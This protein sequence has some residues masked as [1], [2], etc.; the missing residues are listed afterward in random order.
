MTRRLAAAGAACAVLGLARLPSLVLCKQVLEG[1]APTPWQVTFDKKPGASYV[2]LN[3]DGGERE[4]TMSC[5]RWFKTYTF[6]TTCSTRRMW[7]KYGDYE[8]M[9]YTSPEGNKM[10]Y[11]KAEAVCAEVQAEIVSIHSQS[12]AE[13]VLSLTENNRHGIWISAVRSTDPKDTMRLDGKKRGGFTS[14]SDDTPWDYIN[15]APDEPSATCDPVKASNCNVLFDVNDVAYYS[16]AEKCVS[17]GSTDENFDPRLW[18][19]VS[20]EKHRRLVCKRR[21]VKKTW[22]CAQ[23]NSHF[24]NVANEIMRNG[25]TIWADPWICSAYYSNSDNPFGE[26]FCEET[27]PTGGRTMGNTTYA[28]VCPIRC[29]GCTITTTTATLP[30]DTT[31]TSPAPYTGPTTTTTAGPTSTEGPTTTTTV[32]Y[33]TTSTE[34]PST[35]TAYVVLPCL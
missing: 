27:I 22:E 13:F 34:A 28:D 35:T 18:N 2:H 14:W 6:D 32:T 5:G 1:D 19:D 24:G 16:Y 11:E 10:Q 9:Y 23:Y 4:A 7:H 33:G 21:Y 15:W 25:T 31:S 20:C 30:E 12:E 29:G 26:N 17:M 3:D 8:Y